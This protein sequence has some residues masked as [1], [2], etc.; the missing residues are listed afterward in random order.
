MIPCLFILRVQSSSLSVFLITKHSGPF[1]LVINNKKHLLL[2][3]L[4][5]TKTQAMPRAT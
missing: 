3:F 4:L 5:I 1:V 2:L